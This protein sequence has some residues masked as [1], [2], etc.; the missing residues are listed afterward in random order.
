MFS[1]PLTCDSTSEATDD[2]ITAALAPG[3][4]A[5]T[6]TCGGV[7]FGYF[8]SCKPN[9]ETKPTSVINIDIT[10]AKRGFVMKKYNPFFFLLS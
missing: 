10:I 2:S 5:D 3:Y 6:V 7:M 1:T 9:M 8:S 4:E